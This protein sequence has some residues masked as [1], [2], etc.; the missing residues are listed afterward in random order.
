MK[1]TTLLRV[2]PAVA[3]GALALYAGIGFLALPAIVKSQAVQLAAD[4]LQRQ[5]TI[6]DVTFNPF[7]LAMDIRGFKLMEPK[8]GAVFVSFDTLSLDLAGESLWRMAPVVQQVRLAQ[9]YVHLVR[10]DAYHYSIAVSYT[11]LTLP[12]I[13]SV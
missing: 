12:T 8:G 4:K 1:K 10:T 5:L 7:T 13:C 3:A 11:H 9:P 6:D 2:V